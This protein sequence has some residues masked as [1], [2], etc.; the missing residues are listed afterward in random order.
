MVL[1]KFQD[2][3]GGMKV[4]WDVGVTKVKWVG[5]QIGMSCGRERG[6]KTGGVWDEIIGVR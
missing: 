5:V 1:S 4:R 2:K 3:W 6:G